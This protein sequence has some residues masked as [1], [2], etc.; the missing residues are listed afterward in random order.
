MKHLN[1][2]GCTVT[3]TGLHEK[4]LAKLIRNLEQRPVRRWRVKARHRGEDIQLDV[5]GPGMTQRS[6]VP[7]ALR[8]WN[9][10]LPWANNAAVPY[11]IRVWDV[12]ELREV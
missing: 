5:E 3:V 4:E 2:M 11:P 12:V 10:I 7:E 8:A 1:I 6:A 9:A